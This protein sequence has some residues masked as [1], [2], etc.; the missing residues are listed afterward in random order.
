MCDS[1]DH[2]TARHQHRLPTDF[3]F[4]DSSFAP[5][6]VEIDPAR[7]MNKVTLFDHKLITAVLRF[8]VQCAMMYEVSAERA[9]RTA[10]RRIF[11]NVV[12]RREETSVCPRRA[13][14]QCL[15]R[16][17]VTTRRLV[18]LIDVREQRRIHAN[19]AQV[20]KRSHRNGDTRQSSRDRLYRQTLVEIFTRESERTREFSLFLTVV[21]LVE[22]LKLALRHLDLDRITIS[23]FDI[24][25][26]DSNADFVINALPTVATFG[27]WYHVFFRECGPGADDR[28]PSKRNLA[29]RREDAQLA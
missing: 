14:F 16:K 9:A 29:H 10:R 21:D 22:D 28:M 4:L 7:T 15:A 2:R 20:R 3:H 13:D 26:Q 8:D 12:G 19:V 17:R 24:D 23:E 5:F 27:H 6:N 11:G 18:P 1:K 25:R